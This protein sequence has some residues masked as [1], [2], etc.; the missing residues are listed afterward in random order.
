MRKPQAVSLERALN[1]GGPADQNGRGQFFVHHDLHG[2]QY[3]LILALG[4][5]YAA[6]F[7]G[8]LAGG[9]E[10]R[11]HERAAVIDELQQALAVRFQIKRWDG[12]PRR[13]PSRPWRPQERS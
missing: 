12:S 5:D 1:D 11:L 6:M 7:R 10:N 3:A 2:A 8:N 9:D 13:T 4:I